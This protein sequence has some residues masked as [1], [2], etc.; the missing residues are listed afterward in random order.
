[1]KVDLI[2][3]RD[4]AAS[5]ASRSKCIYHKVSALVRARSRRSKDPPISEPMRMSTYALHHR[6]VGTWLDGV[7][8]KILVQYSPSDIMYFGRVVGSL[9]GRHIQSSATYTR[10]ELT[11]AALWSDWPPPND[12]GA[13]LR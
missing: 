11:S 10:N 7:E 2:A 3:V 8:A 13:A 5:A 6:Q 12:G 4:E 1:M 9:G